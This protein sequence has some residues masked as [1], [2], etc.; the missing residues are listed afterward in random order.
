MAS[1]HSG[2]AIE[3]AEVELAA[4]K[5]ADAP[6]AHL[7]GTAP[8]AFPAPE[9]AALRAFVETGGVLLIDSCGG[10][11]TFVQSAEQ[12]LIAAA[13]ADAKFDPID[14]KARY[15]TY[16]LARDGA[17]PTKNPIEHAAVGKGHVYLSRADITSGLLG[18]REWGIYGF[19]PEYATELVSD[20][21]PK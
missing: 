1:G 6:I 16:V 3:S 19:E 12:N 2:V 21:L 14:S 4:L 17:Q 18:T 10:G 11:D 7:T 5:P 15:R 9:A 20:L 13:F 8:H